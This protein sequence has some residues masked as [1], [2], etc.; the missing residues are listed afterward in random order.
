M[1]NSGTAEEQSHPAEV[2][3][4]D[5][6]ADLATL[7]ITGARNVPAPLDVTQEAPVRETMPVLIFGFPGGN[8]KITIGEG[9]ITQLRRDENNA[10]N[11]VQLAGEIAP[12]NSGGPVVDSQGR[13]IGIAVATVRGK[14]IGFAIPAGQLD[15]MLKGSVLAGI[16]F[17]VKQQ[18]TRFDGTGELWILDRKSKVL[19]RN[20]FQSQISAG[21][22]A[23][24]EFVVLA[25][26][27]DPMHKVSAV[28][29]HF[30]QTASVPDRPG[31]TGWAP[32]AAR[33]PYPSRSGTTRPAARSSCPPGPS[34]T[35]RSPSSS[36]T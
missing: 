28:K 22:T 33:R 15:H 7:R 12:G 10:L 30:A 9:K 5:P 36:P 1:L 32:L 24:N 34:P 4:I 19:G 13:L 25:A 17:Q 8:R 29:A 3:A 11:D 14:N 6:E 16:V 20:I 31:P 26:L 23:P 18:G 21:A 27:N 2:V 35:T